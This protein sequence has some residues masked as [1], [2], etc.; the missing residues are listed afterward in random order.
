MSNVAVDAEDLLAAE[1]ALA[2]ARH[3]EAALSV[4]AVGGVAPAEAAEEA[5]VG[6]GAG[7]VRCGGGDMMHA[8]H[9]S[10]PHTYRERIE[11]STS[12]FKLIQSTATHDYS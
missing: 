6:E 5:G 12:L 2:D 10:R 4:G 7:T 1:A 3:C 11:R 8:G 9:R